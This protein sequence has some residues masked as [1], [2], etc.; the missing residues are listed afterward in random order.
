MASKT[1][2]TRVDKEL[3]RRAQI[4][5][6]HMKP[7]EIFKVGFQFLSGIDASGRFIYGKNVW[8]KITKK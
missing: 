7:Q 6:P 3:L 4:E 2:L 8:N 5:M 1:T